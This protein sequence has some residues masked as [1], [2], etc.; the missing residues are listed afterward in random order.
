[1]Q[2]LAQKFKKFHQK[3][4]ISFKSVKV[5]A[6]PADPVAA[7]NWSGPHRAVPL[8]ERPV[9]QHRPPRA[10]TAI[11][12]DPVLGE[13]HFGSWGPPPTAATAER[14]VNYQ[15]LDELYASLGGGDGDGDLTIDGLMASMGGGGDDLTSSDMAELSAE[16]GVAFNSDEQLLKHLRASSQAADER[17]DDGQV[18]REI[19]HILTRLDDDAGA[20]EEP[21]LQVG[22]TI[23]LDELDAQ[24]D[25]VEKSG[26]RLAARQGHVIKS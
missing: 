4:G 17:L 12:A 20:N 22:T 25:S 8:T 3:H 18:S 9:P 16:L 11:I 1:M 15:A 7:L 23:S 19:D 21:T 26:N 14:T 2:G 5:E 24:L 6:K 13:V 10:S